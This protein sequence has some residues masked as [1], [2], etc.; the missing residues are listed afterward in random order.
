M[1][2][3]H[4]ILKWMIGPNRVIGI[5]LLAASCLLLGCEADI[6][7]DCGGVGG[8]IS[9]ISIDSIQPVD[10]NGQASSNVDALPSTCPD[11]SVELFTDHS[12]TITF[13]NRPFPSSDSPT[14]VNTDGSLLLTILNYSVTYTLNDCPPRATGCPALT[15]FSVSP[16]QTFTIPANGSVS[17]TFPMVPLRVKEEYVAEGGHLGA[18][19]FGF[20]FPSYTA[21]YVFTGR[22]DFFSDDIRIQGSTEFTIGSF[23]GCGG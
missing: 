13:A 17:D 3:S 14:Q 22:T 16:G 21:T 23:S 7:E 18:S 4:T 12:A 15:G 8:V 6:R 9:C 5:G 20:P 10:E 19:D 11:G 2:R 1:V